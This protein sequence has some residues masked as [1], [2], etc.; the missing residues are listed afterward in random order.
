[1]TG[2]NR[3]P[4]APLPSRWSTNSRTMVRQQR[5]R[6]GAAGRAVAQHDEEQPDREDRP[7]AEQ[8]RHERRERRDR[9]DLEPED[10]AGLGHGHVEPVQTRSDHQREDERRR[11]GEAQ[12]PRVQWSTRRPPAFARTWKTVRKPTIVA[13]SI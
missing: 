13:T 9:Q 11:D 5:W 7:T 8:H 2:P 1:M 10:P 3:R 6:D 12:D 4:T